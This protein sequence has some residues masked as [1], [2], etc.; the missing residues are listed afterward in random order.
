[1]K[2]QEGQH[3]R[4]SEQVCEDPKWERAW[5]V[6]GMGKGR[7]TEAQRVRSIMVLKRGAEVRSSRTSL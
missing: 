4:E 2:M 1:M 6:R 5:C 3:S 7:L